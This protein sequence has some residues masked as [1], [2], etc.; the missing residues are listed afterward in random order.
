MFRNLKLLILAILSI[1][2]LLAGA[3]LL[4]SWLFQTAGV[5]E[6]APEWQLNDVDGNRM[7]LADFKA[8][9]VIL[10]FWATWCPPCLEEI[11]GFIALQ[12]K[13]GDGSLTIIGVSLDKQGPS[14]VKSFMRRF[15]MN[16]PVVMNDEKIFADYGGIEVWVRRIARTDLT[17]TR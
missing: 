5:S 1:A 13:Y 15:G 17:K 11:P 9:V 3:A 12:E 6:T 8:K 4:C 14:V 2:A 16:Y 10:D 7:K